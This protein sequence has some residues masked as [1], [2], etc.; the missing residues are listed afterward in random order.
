MRFYL[1]FLFLLSSF[2][3]LS[4]NGF[5]QENEITTET[6]ESDL[7]RNSSVYFPKSIGIVND[8]NNLF[9]NKQKAELDQMLYYY[10][11]ETTRQIVVVSVNSIA[12]YDDIQQYA[13]DLGSYWGVG[14]KESNNGLM[15]VVCKPCRSFGI[16]TGLGTQEVLTDEICKT[17]IDETIIP[18]FKNGNFYKGIKD[19]VVELIEKWD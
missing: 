5:A 14:Q 4:C 19:G 15:I 12:P 10:E 6:A 2:L 16:A 11:I 13:T 18:A 1:N 9:T 17:V 3:L 8:Y 7:S